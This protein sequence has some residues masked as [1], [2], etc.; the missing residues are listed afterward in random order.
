[1]ISALVALVLA[2]EPSV[3]G[4][5]RVENRCIAVRFRGP[6]F[7]REVLHTWDGSCDDVVWSADGSVLFVPQ[8]LDLVDLRT[9]KVTELQLF[10]PGMIP[11]AYAFSRANTLLAF[12]RTDQEDKQKGFVWN[13]LFCPRGEVQGEA[14]LAH[15][16]E[17]DGKAWREVEKSVQN[18]EGLESE[19]LGPLGV[20]ELKTWHAL[21]RTRTR[22]MLDLPRDANAKELAALPK[23]DGGWRTDGQLAGAIYAQDACMSM[24]P[25]AVKTK[26]GWK[27]LA[28]DKVAPAEGCVQVERKPGLVFISGDLGSVLCDASTGAERFF[29]PKN[30]Q[31]A[32]L[33]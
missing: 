31:A 33:R 23:N 8:M 13:G 6:S 15:A 20:R 29:A 7:T 27:V 26:T 32:A 3:L 21:P 22:L 5:E 9:K 30:V 2:A 19:E 14:R 17:F 16:F 28:L 10:P 12:S 11:E 1:M 18:V 24:T 4:V 25:I